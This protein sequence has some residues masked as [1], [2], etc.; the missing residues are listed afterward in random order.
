[1]GIIKSYDVEWTAEPVGS[2]DTFDSV[3][4]QLGEAYDGAAYNPAN[5]FLTL[6]RVD[7][8]PNSF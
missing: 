4:D 7:G 5:G 1:M 6:T 3:N 2:T 8:Q